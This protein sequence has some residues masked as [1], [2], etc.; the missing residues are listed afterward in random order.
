MT[1]TKRILTAAVAGAVLMAGAVVA[2]A[3]PAGAAVH[4]LHAERAYCPV[5]G[6][7][8]THSA[9]QR[10]TTE[11]SQPQYPMSPVASCEPPPDLL[12]QAYPMGHICRFG[13]LWCYLANPPLMPIGAAC[14]CT[15][16]FCGTVTDW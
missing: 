9:L 13:Y 14:C 4:T 12:A 3:Y 15:A 5:G 11:P 1:M 2:Q 8:A 10:M 7:P 6:G 16:G